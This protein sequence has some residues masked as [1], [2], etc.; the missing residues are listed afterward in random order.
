[1]VTEIEGLA[2]EVAGRGRNS[3]SREREAKGGGERPENQGSG[4]RQT[5][6]GED[7]EPQ[8]K[9]GAF[10]QGGRDRL[11]GMERMRE[12]E[13]ARQNI[14][15]TDAQRMCELPTNQRTEIK[16]QRQVGT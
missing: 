11:R 6:R 9:E 4:G 2:R 7:L 14:R 10:R 12:R 16:T 15:E 3:G 1:M 8:G 5:P 13:R